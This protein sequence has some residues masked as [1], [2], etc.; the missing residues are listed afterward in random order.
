MKPPPRISIVAGRRARAGRVRPARH[1]DDSAILTLEELF[2]SDRMSLRS[3]RR[4]LA[5]PNAR[6]WVAELDGA[7]V[8][9]LILL[10][11][12][13]SRTARIYSVIVGA[14]ARGHGFGAR[15]VAAAEAEAGRLGMH[16]ISLEARE[17]NSVARHLYAKRGY[18][19]VAK[20][21]SYYEDGADGLQLR[22]AL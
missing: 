4:F 1:S 11:R 7:V 18:V 6:I 13:N 5:S 15:L 21:P 16:A 10:T 19:E 3:V 9:N 2:P 22:K 14:P 17:D 20:L 12:N 8:G